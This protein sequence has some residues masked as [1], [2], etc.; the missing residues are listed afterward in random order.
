[1]TSIEKKEKG[2]VKDKK[3][4]GKGRKSHSPHP[5]GIKQRGGKGQ[6]KKE[7]EGGRETAAL[8][9]ERFF[10]SNPLSAQKKKGSPGEKEKG[11]HGPKPSSF[12]NRRGKEGPDKK[13]RE[14][15]APRAQVSQEKG[16]SWCSLFPFGRMKPKRYEQRE[17]KNMPA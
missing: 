9:C 3:K 5:P 15:T 2:G 8:F 14:K 1:L 6:K 16:R 10:V 4:R 13:G 7:T 17:K 11:R 12:V